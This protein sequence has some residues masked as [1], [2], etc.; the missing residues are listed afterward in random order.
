MT[1]DI[2]RVLANSAVIVG[3]APKRIVVWARDTIATQQPRI[4]DTTAAPMQIMSTSEM[5]ALVSDT[6]LVLMNTN[7]SGHLFQVWDLAAGALVA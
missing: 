5:S 4:I 7:P 1:E 6:R 3:V 2:R